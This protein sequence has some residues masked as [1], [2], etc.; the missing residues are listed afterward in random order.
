MEAIARYSRNV[1]DLFNSL[2]PAMRVV[3]VLLAAVVVVGLAFLFVSPMG[4]SGVYLLGGYRFNATEV[5][6]A[7]A[8]FSK[9]GLGGSVVEGNQIRVPGGTEAD[10]VAAM[11][12]AE[13]LPRNFNQILDDT[14]AKVSP[15]MPPRQREELIKNAKQRELAN[16]IRSMADVDAAAVLYDR[17]RERGLP[18]RETLTASVTV[19]PTPGTPLPR[20]RFNAIRRLVARSI[21][22][23]TE[24]NVSVIDAGGGSDPSAEDDL[25]GD[26]EGDPYMKATRRH[27]RRVVSS[28]LGALEYVPGVRISAIVKLDPELGTTEEIKD[29]NDKNK[30]AVTVNDR[31]DQS[32]TDSKPE[33]GRP[34]L[35]AQSHSN[36]AHRLDGGGGS[37]NSAV[38]KTNDSTQQFVVGHT[39]KQRRTVGL[40]PTSA[41]VS[42]S[43]PSTHFDTV[44]AE[45]KRKSEAADPPQTAASPKQ[46]ETAELAKI[47][48]TVESIMSDLAEKTSVHVESFVHVPPVKPGPPSIMTRGVDWLSRY[49]STLGVLGLSA[50]GLV[51]L[52]SMVKSVPP[53]EPLPAVE[54]PRP[55]DD[56]PS[57]NGDSKQSPSVRSEL[58]QLVRDDPDTAANVIRGWISSATP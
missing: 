2:S 20:Q 37:G 29:V 47:Q 22:G 26:S 33:G 31:T 44:W 35:S 12:D 24:A 45:L 1:G 4:E 3:A 30:A 27:E 57:D 38:Q 53:P 34:G 55:G 39:I 52:R 49:W 17:R 21:A 10:Y 23:L 5:T 11:A 6:A 16:I 9:A 19:W 7:Q 28:V 43:V 8:A 56:N 42:V 51:M 54:A 18:V 46:V 58:A 14:L 48:K 41:S 36:R 50:F 32:T 25:A 40:T 13:V 15:F